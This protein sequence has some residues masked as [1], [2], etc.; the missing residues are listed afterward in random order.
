MQCKSFAL[1]LQT[2]ETTGFGSKQET[3]TENRTSKGLLIEQ[4]YLRSELKTKQ[5]SKSLQTAM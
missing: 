1:S 2:M 4:S 5:T 3:E